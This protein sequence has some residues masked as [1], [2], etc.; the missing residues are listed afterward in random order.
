MPR[1]RFT[2]D[3]KLEIIMDLSKTELPRTAYL[4]S[5]GADQYS[6]KGCQDIYNQ[7]GLEERNNWTLYS[8]KAKRKSVAAH[9]NN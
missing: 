9:L 3:E 1:T 4:K 6:V 2:P 7:D 5:Y 8:E